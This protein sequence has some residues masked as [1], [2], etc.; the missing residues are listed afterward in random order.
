MTK[1]VVCVFKLTSSVSREDWNVVIGL[2]SDV[3][4]IRASPHARCSVFYDI[5]HRL[6][7]T[8]AGRCLVLVNVAFEYLSRNSVFHLS[9]CDNYYTLFVAIA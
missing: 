3:N 7:Q 1:P 8:L 2:T 4:S 6:L 9:H 5:I